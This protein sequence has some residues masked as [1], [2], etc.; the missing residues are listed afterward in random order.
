MSQR[1]FKDGIACCELCQAGF[2]KFI[3]MLVGD[4]S[5][6]EVVLPGN[7]HCMHSPPCMVLN[8]HD[9]C[10]NIVWVQP[11]AT[12]L[13]WEPHERRTATRCY[14]VACLLDGEITSL[15]EIGASIV[16]GE[17]TL[18]AEIGASIVWW[19]ALRVLLGFGGNGVNAAG[20]CALCHPSELLVASCAAAIPPPALQAALQSAD[21]QTIVGSLKDMLYKR[22]M[23]RELLRAK[24]EVWYVEK[25]G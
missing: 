15:A 5:V 3:D 24:G 13:D 22:R 17:I 14:P 20:A 25:R 8:Q 7:V 11:A 2:I 23:E 16:D 18:L 10:Y 1:F 4:G 12:K 19:S 9:C 6:V 21:K